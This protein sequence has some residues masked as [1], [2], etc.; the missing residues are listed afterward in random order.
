MG[1]LLEYNRDDYPTAMCCYYYPELGKGDYEEIKK[2][3]VQKMKKEIPS[4]GIEPGF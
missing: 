4:P 2:N 1:V 3:T